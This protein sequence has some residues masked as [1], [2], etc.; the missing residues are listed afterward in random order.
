MNSIPQQEVAKG[1]GQ[2]ELLRA[3]PT[4]SANLVAKKPSPLKPAGAS[5]CLIFILCVTGRMNEL[6]F[7][8]KDY[9]SQFKAPFLN[10]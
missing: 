1:K 9:S 6:D 3:N 4:A 5:T 10:M 7:S 8:G 2:I